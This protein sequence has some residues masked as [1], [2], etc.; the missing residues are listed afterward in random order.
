MKMRARTV[1]A[2]KI[3]PLMGIRDNV[4]ISV[5]GTLTLGWELTL[6]VAYSCTEAE[7]DDMI[8]AFSSA[9]SVLPAWTIIHRQDLFTYDTWKAPE[10][11]AQDF[12]TRSYEEHFEGRRYLTHRSYLFL[13]LSTKGLIEKG[14]RSSGLFGLFASVKVPTRQDLNIF[15]TKAKEFISLITASGHIK[16]KLMGET[17]WLGD[18]DEVG[19][20]QRVMM[21]G[22]ESPIMSH[23][24]LAPDAV[25]VKNRTMNCFIIGE[26]DQLPSEISS[27]IRVD[28]L[29]SSTNTV[30]LSTG[31]ALGVTLDCEHIVNQYIV[32]PS[33]DEILHQLDSE[34][35]KMTSGISSAD[36]RIN[37]AEIQKFLDDAYANGLVAV[38]SHTNI[39]FWGDDESLPDLSATVS[40]AIHS[41]N[42]TRGVMNLYNTP[43]LYYAAIPG[44]AC[45]IS[46]ENLMT[47]ELVSSLCFG[48]YE[49]FEKD[50][51]KGGVLQICDRM[52][53]I[54]LRTDTQFVAQQLDWINNYDIFVIGGSGTGK[55]FFMNMYTRNLYHNGEQTF[56]IDVGH[57]YQGITQVINEETHGADGQYLSWDMDHPLSFNPFIGF[58]KWV[59][60]E[61][62][63]VPDE[64]GVNFVV[65]LL[66]TIYEPGKG[67][68]SSNEPILKQTLLD[69]VKYAMDNGFSEENLPTIDDY[70]AFTGKVISPQLTKKKYMVGDEEVGTAEFNIKDFRL[71]LK[72]YSLTGEFS[73][74]LNDKTPKD[75]FTSRYIVFEV[76]KLSDVK[77]RKFYSI[78]ILCMM[79]A[80]DVKMRSGDGFKNLIIEEAWKAI[81][82]ETMAP[83]LKGLWKT[84]RKHSTSCVVVTQELTDIISSDVI[85]DAILLN[86]DIRV[87]L[88]Q[89]NNRNILTAEENLG[90]KD[91]R[92]ML[93]LS[94]KEIDIILSLNRSKNPNYNYK[95]VFIKYINGHSGV[96]A[97]EVSQ[98]E[99]LCYESNMKKKEPL[100][101]LAKE[102]GSIIKAIKTMTKL[103]RQS[104]A[105]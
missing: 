61:G 22:E 72:A 24:A 33:Q 74:L 21:L 45:D 10:D 47:M 102:K 48:I 87:L 54:P 78:C 79:N 93:G 56:I 43:V 94:P 66:E 60:K 14:G 58:T 81:A 68:V 83:Y 11:P 8:G 51:P 86:S 13:S 97:T 4:A 55:S 26:S 67:W 31:S 18:K 100:L 57:S 52:R 29:S 15:R 5:N 20:I 76:S 3:F 32:V 99:A 70:F 80:F 19:A 62:N 89:Q 91:I 39:M 75:L 77:D 65:S 34:R 49:T 30:F 50:V 35:K 44:A 25:R 41:M 101:K 23:V 71:A 16:A 85:K 90:D 36:N 64:N 82:N 42:Q 27:V 53:N 46:K 9:I 103:L 98:E 38:K 7:Y 73:F 59:T 1:R 40:T 104:L 92:T 88:D 105:A 37:S 95:E 12:L 17:D 69:F 28:K 84:A 2:E 96:Y 6:P 63:L